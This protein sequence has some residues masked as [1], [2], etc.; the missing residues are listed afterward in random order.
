[1]TKANLVDQISES[2][3][4]TKSD[5]A[6]ALEVTLNAIMDAV[7]DGQKVTLIGFGTFTQSKRV[8]RQGRNPRTGEAIT[9]PST[10]APK[11][12]AGKMFKEIL[13]R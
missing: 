2:T 12:V 7:K 10:N 9:I 3:D 11:F 13:N 6:K 1:M 5:A 4:L 8:A